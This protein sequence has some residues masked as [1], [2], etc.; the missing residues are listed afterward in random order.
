MLRSAL[1][2][3][4]VVVCLSA[5]TAQAAAIQFYGALTSKVGSGGTLNFAVPQL[6]T[7]YMSVNDSV[8]NSTTVAFG[9]FKFGNTE[10]TVSGGQV[11]V[12]NGDTIEFIFGTSDTT[13]ATLNGN[14]VGTPGIAAIAFS[15]N[16]VTG[17]GV[18]INSY[19]L[20]RLNGLTTNFTM[21]ENGSLPLYAGTITA[22]PEPSSMLVLGGLVAGFGSWRYRR[23]KLAQKAC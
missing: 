20:G 17:L 21:L 12:L 8:T 19:V 13:L 9:G 3:L 6:F 11:N 2:T 10:I 18:G 22:I 5:S 4:A 15:F 23:R 7:A 14:P 16:G 1:L